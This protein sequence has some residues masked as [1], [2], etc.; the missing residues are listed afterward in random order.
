[1]KKTIDKDYVALAEEVCPVCGHAHKDGG[2]ILFHT[3]LQNIPEDK[4]VIGWNLCK[5]HMKLHEDGFL[6]LVVCDKTKS[7]NKGEHAH[8]E[9]AYRTGELI[10]VRRTVVPILF[11][12]LKPEAIEQPMMFISENA[13]KLIKKQVPDG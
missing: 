7:V 8:M 3:R 5:E 11:R 10:H 12:D 4:R 9:D 13:A 1:M 6:A 2:A